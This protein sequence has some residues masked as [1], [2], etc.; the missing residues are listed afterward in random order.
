MGYELTLYVV[1]RKP[2]FC[3]DGVIDAFPDASI[4]LY[5]PGYESEIY[6]LSQKFLVAPMPKERCVI[7]ESGTKYEEFKGGYAKTIEVVKH[8]D[9]YGK[10]MLPCPISDVINA[11]EEDNKET[12]YRRF[13]IALALLKEYHKHF[14]EAH[15]LF[16]GH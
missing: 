11:L 7:Y 1:G 2:T 15:V 6:N 16:W 14:N 10:S 9:L 13:S 8:V 5:K 3:L 4:D 12:E